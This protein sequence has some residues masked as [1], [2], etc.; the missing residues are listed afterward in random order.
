VGVRETGLSGVVCSIHGDVMVS[1][2]QQYRTHI[3]DRK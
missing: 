3:R 1:N 2:R